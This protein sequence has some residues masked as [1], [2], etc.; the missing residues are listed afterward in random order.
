MDTRL[1]HNSHKSLKLLAPESSG[2]GL[3]HSMVFFYLHVLFMRQQLC[4][5]NAISHYPVSASA[6]SIRQVS[7][8]PH[9]VAAAGTIKG[10]NV[11]N[12]L[13]R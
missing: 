4:C 12:V 10:I 5:Q 1:D 13:T 7:I 6:G 11:I 2:R 9:A 3:S 8:K